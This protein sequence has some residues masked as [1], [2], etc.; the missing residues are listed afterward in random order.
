MNK[1]IPCY[2]AIVAHTGTGIV[3]GQAIINGEKSYIV[4][5]EKE[6]KWYEA[7]RHGSLYSVASYTKIQEV[8]WNSDIQAFTS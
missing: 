8:F 4:C 6:D 7:V 1:D 5:D 3:C 2:C